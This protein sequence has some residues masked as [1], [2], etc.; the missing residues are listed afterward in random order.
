MVK[1]ILFSYKIRNKIQSDIISNNY[2]SII[3]ISIK[4]YAIFSYLSFLSINMLIKLRSHRR[5]SLELWL[6]VLMVYEW[7]KMLL[8]ISITMMITI[9][10]IAVITVMWLQIHWRKWRNTI[11][12]D[13]RSGFGYQMTKWNF[14]IIIFNNVMVRWRSEIII[15]KWKFLMPYLMTFQI[16]NFKVDGDGVELDFLPS[17]FW[18]PKF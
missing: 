7:I 4:R 1:I 18:N 8:V 6:H 16:S 17:G 12:S 3:K 14:V 11:S 10:M 13:L 5:R 9:S 2:N 15:K